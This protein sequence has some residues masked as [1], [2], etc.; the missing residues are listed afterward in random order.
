M[1]ING[2]DIFITRGDTEAI[3]VVLYDEEENIIPFVI[4]DTVYFTVKQSTQTGIKEFQKVITIFTPEGEA[5]IQIDSEDTNTLKY[6]DYVY[7]VQMVRLSDGVTTIIPP[8]K[9]TIG[10]EVTYE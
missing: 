3:T 9:F 4:G 8:S 10:E 6:D 7:D 1:K 5:I 2:T